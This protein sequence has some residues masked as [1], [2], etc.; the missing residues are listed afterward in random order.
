[1]ELM[2]VPQIAF[3]TNLWL[4]QLLLILIFPN[5]RS[6]I[7]CRLLKLLRPRNPLVL[8]IIWYL[9]LLKTASNNISD[10]IK[11]IMVLL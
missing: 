9:E 7:F 1:M 5:T 6:S 4:L 8:Q 2:L 11:F 10:V 3:L